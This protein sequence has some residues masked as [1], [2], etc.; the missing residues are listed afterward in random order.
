VPRCG[1]EEAN[2]LSKFEMPWDPVHLPEPVNRRKPEKE[3]E[4]HSGDALAGAVFCCE[5][6]LLPDE[7]HVSYI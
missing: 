2:R 3:S 6:D 5:L 7:D 4:A 1:D